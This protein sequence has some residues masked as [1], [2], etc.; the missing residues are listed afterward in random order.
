MG[1][2]GRE[3]HCRTIDSANER[4]VA[5]G[6]HQW[7]GGIAKAQAMLKGEGPEPHLPMELHKHENSRTCRLVRVLGK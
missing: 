1:E 7:G 6:V 4:S 2:L 3:L 5:T